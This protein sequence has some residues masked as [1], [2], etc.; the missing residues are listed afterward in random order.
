MKRVI[1]KCLLIVMLLLFSA[2]FSF[3]ISST[4]SAESTTEDKLKAI[5]LDSLGLRLQSVVYKNTTYPLAAITN[6][7][8]N[9]ATGRLVNYSISTAIINNTL[10]TVRYLDQTI[11]NSISQDI[12]S[13]G[14]HKAYGNYSL[15]FVTIDCGNTN[16]NELQNSGTP[17]LILDDYINQ[18]NGI[19]S[20]Y[21][22]SIG[23]S[24]SLLHYNCTYSYFQSTYSKEQLRNMYTNITFYTKE[25]HSTLFDYIKNNTGT[26]PKKFDIPIVAIF[27]SSSMESCWAYGGVL[28]TIILNIYWTPTTVV[29]PL[30]FQNLCRTALEHEMLH[31]NG[32]AHDWPFDY[33]STIYLNGSYP[34]QAIIPG[35]LFG[36]TDVDGDS[37]VEI[38]DNNPYGVQPIFPSPSPTLPLPTP[39]SSPTP[40]PSTTPTSTPSS[41]PTPAATASPSPSAST[42]PTLKPQSSQESP[43]VLYSIIATAAFASIGAAVFMLKRKR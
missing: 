7:N 29:T 32:W 30:W 1:L 17:R 22:A 2:I 34:R 11:Y 20:N 18:I 24:K 13:N 5:Y 4:G 39:T 9:T 8:G 41:T 37:V 15:L 21:S 27:D 3:Q 10:Y 12:L 43:L 36:W 26:D 42:T 23:L 25:W 35:S 40:R 31:L 16:I 14:W 33:Y 38:M 19:Y 28:P 6:N